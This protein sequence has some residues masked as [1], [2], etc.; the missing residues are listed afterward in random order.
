MTIVRRLCMITVLVIC[1]LSFLLSMRLFLNL[2]A[3]Y[4]FGY[5][6]YVPL[7]LWLIHRTSPKFWALYSLLG[8]PVLLAVAV[9]SFWLLR[10]WLPKPKFK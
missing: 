3:S 4:G 1:G 5:G 2:V 7:P 6:S 9:V 10:R 8:G